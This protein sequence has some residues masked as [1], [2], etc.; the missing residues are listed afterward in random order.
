MGAISDFEGHPVFDIQT[1]GMS[2]G[3]D[4]RYNFTSHIFVDQ[5]T[6]LPIGG[7]YSTTHSSRDGS[8]IAS[9]IGITRYRN[10]FLDATS[11]PADFFAP[12]SI[13]YIEPSN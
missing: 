12:S 5:P 13:G 11:L 6:H 2:R 1:E 9:P 7:T 10:E 4:A 8:T 3:S